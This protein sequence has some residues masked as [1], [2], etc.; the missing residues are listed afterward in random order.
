M[1]L[2]RRGG[3]ESYSCLPV[4]AEKVGRS[5]TVSL[6]ACHPCLS[7]RCT[8]SRR[9]IL[10]IFELIHRTL[11][12]MLG[13]FLA[14]GVLYDSSCVPPSSTTHRCTVCFAGRGTWYWMPRRRYILKV[15]LSNHAHALRVRGACIHRVLLLWR[16]ACP[17][18]VAAALTVRVADDVMPHRNLQKFGPQQ[19]AVVGGGG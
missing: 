19:T 6:L 14:L 9:Y 2:G 15:T 10:I 7:R 16:C 4:D 11:A 12:A 1:G 13:S 3:G 17:V 18:V 5:R 8:V